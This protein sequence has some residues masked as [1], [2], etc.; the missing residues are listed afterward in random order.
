[1]LR[2]CLDDAEVLQSFRLAAEDSA[3]GSDP[4]EITKVFMMASMTAL[5]KSERRCSRIAA[6]T[7][8]RRL[9][10]RTLARQCMQVVEKTPDC[11]LHFRRVLA[12]CVGH[13]VRGATDWTH[14]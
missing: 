4:E 13:A 9:V 2:V 3:R 10:A 12:M 1:M 7:S 6:G 14:A 11:N 5:R 8:F